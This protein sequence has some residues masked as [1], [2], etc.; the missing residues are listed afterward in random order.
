[1]QPKGCISYYSGP[2]KEEAM[3]NEVYY[4]LFPSLIYQWVAG[5]CHAKAC[6]DTCS[7][8]FCSD[9]YRG[10]IHFHEHNV[11]ELAIEDNR[12]DEN[13]FYLHF[14]MTDMKIIVDH[15]R[16]F[17]HFLCGHTEEVSL[18]AS[19]VSSHEQLKILLSCTAGL[20][21]SYFAYLMQE[22][23]AP[24][25]ENI[26]IDAVSYLDLDQVQQDYDIILLAPQIAYKYPELKER[27]GSKL[28]KIDT[29]DFATGNVNHVLN[30]VL[31]VH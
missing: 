19:K 8:Y 27:Y 31:S 2:K 23:L 6:P 11:V 22:A 7:V 10:R 21:T 4:D 5:M 15:I 13:V 24:L 12:T 30:E 3:M 28:M 26:T 9:P 25:K 1:M 18:D 20:T 14:E 29:L 17:F 16:S